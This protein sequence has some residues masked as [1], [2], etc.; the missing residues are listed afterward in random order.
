M[1]IIITQAIHV[2]AGLILSSD[3]F[4]RILAVVERWADK[5]ISELDKHE[6]V[7]NEIK[8]I[9]L[10][11]ANWEANLGIELAVAYLKHK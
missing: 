1:S 3:V 2:L 5:E 6:S 10:N 11:L 9:G 8:I 4:Q 7:L